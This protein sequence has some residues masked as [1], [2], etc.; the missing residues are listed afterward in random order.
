MGRP[1]T[2]YNCCCAGGGRRKITAQLQ[3]VLVSLV[4]ATDCFYPSNAQSS[5]PVDCSV[6]AFGAKPDDD[7]VDD[8]AAFEAA[9]AACRVR[10]PTSLPPYK[11][12]HIAGNS[13]IEL[14][15][16][17]DAGWPS[18][19]TGRSFSTGPDRRPREYN[20][21]A[22]PQSNLRWHKMCVVGD[23]KHRRA[24]MHF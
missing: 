24:C 14:N 8:S 5:R 18:H 23:L 21:V 10:T 1:G 15:C 3:M 11:H 9:L 7:S 6:T 13:V 22:R 12:G 20:R 16:A 2:S 17:W 19:C 4:L